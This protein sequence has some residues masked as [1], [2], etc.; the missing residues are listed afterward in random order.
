MP[1]HLELNLTTTTTKKKNDGLLSDQKLCVAEQRV[2]QEPNESPLLGELSQMILLT[3][4]DPGFPSLLLLARDTRKEVCLAGGSF[5]HRNADAHTLR[6]TQTHS[7]TLRHAH[8]A[9]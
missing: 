7:D 1:I 9:H 2:V 3:D 4:K 8:S 5:S 6:H